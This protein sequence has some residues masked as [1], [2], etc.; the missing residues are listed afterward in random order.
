MTNDERQELI[1][2]VCAALSPF[3]EELKAEIQTELL[4]PMETRLRDDLRGE[5]GD[6]ETRLRGEMGDMETRLRGEMGDM[7]TRLRDD[8]GSRLDRLEVEVHSIT[9]DVIA[10]FMEA[11]H[12]QH[13]EVVKRLDRLERQIERNRTRINQ[14]FIKVEVQE[15]RLFDISDNVAIIRERLDS[16]ERRLSGESI[17]DVA[18]AELVV[19]EERSVYEMIRDLEKR[20][21]RLEAESGRT[22]GDTK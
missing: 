19:A 17:Y 9:S 3:K 21:A 15:R 11:V 14:M 7:E 22:K 13:E 1:A 16:L 12:K 6:M 4:E 5:M 2:A 8:F 20:M 10:P 18:E